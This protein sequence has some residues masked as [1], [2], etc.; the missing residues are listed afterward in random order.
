MDYLPG[1]IIC[2]I[3]EYFYDYDDLLN[4]KIAC[5]YFDKLITSFSLGKLM[6]YGKFLN[7][8]DTE[9]CANI[10]CYDD[11]CDIY[12][13]IYHFGYRRYIHSHQY[14]SNKSFISINKHLYII[15]TPYCRECFKKYVLIGDKKNIINNLIID[16]VNIEYK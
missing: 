2:Y 10:D 4:L 13:N 1:D 9:M 12:E 5:K 16:E 6:L 14:A 11:T 8:K 15:D 3:K 7:Y